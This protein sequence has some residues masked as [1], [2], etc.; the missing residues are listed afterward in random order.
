MDGGGWVSVVRGGGRRGAVR[1]AGGG[2]A[3]GTGSGGADDETEQLQQRPLQ[4]HQRKKQASGAPQGAGRAEGGGDVV[5]PGQEERQQA[6]QPKDLPP[7]RL[8]SIPTEARRTIVKRVE[9]VD[10]RIGRLQEE[11][12]GGAK[13]RRALQAKEQLTR[14]LRAAG[15][16]TDKAL[17]FSIK[18]EDDRVERAE[19]AL[20]RAIEERDRKQARIAELQEEVA[21]AE[22]GIAHHRQRLQ[23]AREYR[24]YLSMQKWAESASD[25]TI[26]LFKVLAAGMSAQDPE[27][28]RA[29]AVALRLVELREG[30]DEVDM[31]VGDT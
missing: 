3:G 26:T 21:A 11:G 15:G 14:E 28:A 2:G 19:K 16:P 30:R 1:N 29:Q 9:A 23:Q 17:S 22:V 13:L 24:E 20:C 8:L 31:V 27:Q 25:Q 4:D 7:V 5:E 12:A 6:P 10:E 18:G